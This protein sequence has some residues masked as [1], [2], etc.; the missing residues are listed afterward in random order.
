MYLVSL[1]ILHLD[2]L[3]KPFI[4]ISTFT[5]HYTITVYTTVFLKMNLQVRNL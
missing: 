5:T 1:Y 2:I 4:L 3:E